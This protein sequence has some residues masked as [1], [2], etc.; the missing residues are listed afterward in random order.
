MAQTLFHEI[1]IWKK[2]TVFD[3]GSYNAPNSVIHLE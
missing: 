1:H 3:E 2:N